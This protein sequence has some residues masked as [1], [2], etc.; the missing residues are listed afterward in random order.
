MT[1]IHLYF[2]SKP[3]VEKKK[4]SRANVFWNFN[5]I[6]ISSDVSFPMIPNLSHFLQKFIKKTIDLNLIRSLSLFY[7][8]IAFEMKFEFG[9]FEIN[10]K[11]I[12]NSNHI[13][14]YRVLFNMKNNKN[15]NFL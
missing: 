3:E 4:Y 10:F 9:K 2:L 5:M 6:C 15:A 7:Y 13:I 11:Q 8:N 12:I 1:Q 14:F